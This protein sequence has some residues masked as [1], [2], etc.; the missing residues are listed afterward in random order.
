MK[1]VE[2]KSL[3][4]RRLVKAVSADDLVEIQDVI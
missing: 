1:P 2:V 3:L 4:G